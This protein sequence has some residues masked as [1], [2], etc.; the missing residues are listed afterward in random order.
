MNDDDFIVWINF[1]RNK[2]KKCVLVLFFVWMVKSWIWIGVKSSN[3]NGIVCYK[4]LVK[5]MWVIVY[6]YRFSVMLYF[7]YYEFDVFVVV[8]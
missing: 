8:L 2:E 6:V 3:K 7:G 5:D 4:Y 1:L